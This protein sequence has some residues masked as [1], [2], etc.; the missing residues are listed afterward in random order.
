MDATEL[1]AMQAPINAGFT[2]G[3]AVTDALN[4]ACW[5]EAVG[6]GSAITAVHTSATPVASLP[7][8]GVSQVSAT[9]GGCALVRTGGLATAVRC[10]GPNTYGQL[11]NGTTTDQPKPVK[12]R[13]WPATLNR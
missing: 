2:T 5:G 3:C 4:A 6:A 7:A 11:G 1:R 9:L 12:V 13:A 8:G 10:W